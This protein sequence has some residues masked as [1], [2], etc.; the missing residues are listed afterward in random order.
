MWSISVAT[1]GKSTQY[2]LYYCALGEYYYN[3]FNCQNMMYLF[4]LMPLP[5]AAGGAG[6]VGPAPPGNVH[7]RVQGAAGRV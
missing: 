7:R 4:A 2:Y 1:V 3:Y 5:N 6:Q